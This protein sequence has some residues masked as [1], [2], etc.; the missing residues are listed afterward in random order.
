MTATI[1]HLFGT[2]DRGGA[3]TRLLEE[4]SRRGDRDEH[5]ILVALSGQVG[6]LDQAFRA[7]GT[8]VVHQPLSPAFPRWFVAFLRA[9][10]VSH[11]H[12]HVQLT[13]GWF[14]VLARA[15]GVR[16]R[17]A[18]LHSVGDGREDSLGRRTYR[19]GARLA[20]TAG[21]TDVVAVSEAVRAAV[22]GH[23]PLL[24]ARTTVLFDRV[25]GARFA[26]AP[27][28]TP[29]RPIRLVAVGRLDP[30]KDPQRVVG[31]LAT[32]VD[33]GVDAQLRLVGL[34]TPAEQR[35]VQDLAVARRVGHRVEV[36]GARDDVPDLLAGSDLLL[37]ASRREG[38]PGVVLEAAAAGVPAVVSA[39]P[40][41][42]E[43]AR[44]LTGVVPVPLA[45]SDDAWCDV[46]EDVLAARTGHLSPAAVRT[47]F[48][49]SSFALTADHP[50]LDALWT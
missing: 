32:L 7:L 3:E 27:A 6:A 41:N 25:D 35:S 34:A 10:G 9:R 17:I 2:L 39:I 37:S 8:E 23:D 48:D 20:L 45:A 22:V 21:A 4:L 28:P 31:L 36:L 19:A 29:D 40:A 24:R 47:G 33:R 38:L 30:E 18:H 46:I 15:A 50:Q 49:R 42:E 44:W 14:L 5:H 11:L 26:V 43:A 12:S 13:S 16:R 1:V